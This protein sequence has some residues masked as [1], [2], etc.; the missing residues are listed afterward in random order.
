MRLGIRAHDFGRRPVDELAASI[1]AQGFRSVQLALNKAI[2]GPDLRSEDLTPGLAREV[3]RAFAAHGI[4]IAVLGC[5]INPLHPDPTARAALFD[6]FKA[7]LRA[8]RDFGCGVV[9]LESG[10]LNADYSPHADNHSEAAFQA[11][12]RNL[13]ELVEE[14]ERCGVVV[15]LEAVSSHT[16]SNPTKMR[17]VL[18]A[19]GSRCLQ[20]VFDPVNLLTPENHHA[21]RRLI[22]ESMALFGDRIAAV[23]LKDFVA[24]GRALHTR[25]A[26]HGQFD[27][28]PLVSAIAQTQPSADLLLE[29]ATAAVAPSCAG[30]LR[31]IAAIQGI[32]L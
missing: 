23:H 9:A 12:L 27:F 3:R 29:E 18:D 2:A 7:H 20:V 24:D 31:R 15:G 6:W 1:G 14:A 16:V 26:G 5:Y 25:P 32:P 22:E 13:Q 19:I 4:A 28:E 11:L 8:A 10:S 30:L 21:Q 17:R